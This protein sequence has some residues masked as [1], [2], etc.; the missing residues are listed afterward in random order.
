MDGYW[1]SLRCVGVHTTCIQKCGRL[2]TDNNH[3]YLATRDARKREV[4]F[5]E[6]RASALNRILLN[7][8]PN[9]LPDRQIRA[10]FSIATASDCSVRLCE[11]Y[12][13]RIGQDVVQWVMCDWDQGQESRAWG[14]WLLPIVLLYSTDP[15][16]LW[17]NFSPP[18]AE[19]TRRGQPDSWWCQ[20]NIQT[21]GASKTKYQRG[22]SVKPTGMG[23]KRVS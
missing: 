21:R 18:G 14:H 5:R 10:S 13:E 11:I 12:R 16:L 22:R 23:S 3:I 15:F 4:F 20:A 1:K 17:L 6:E 2:R 9:T 7:S 19:R 8:L